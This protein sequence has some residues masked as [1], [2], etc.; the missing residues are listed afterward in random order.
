M[1]FVFEIAEDY[2]GNTVS[3]SSG[4]MECQVIQLIETTSQYIAQ[5][6]ASTISKKKITEILV[7]WHDP[8]GKTNSG[9]VLKW[10]FE[11]CT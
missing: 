2:S 6:T 3:W 9:F 5:N 10:N 4:L 7:T 8:T 1:H 11:F